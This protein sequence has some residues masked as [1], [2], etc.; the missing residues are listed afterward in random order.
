MLINILYD[1]KNYSIFIYVL[2]CH[3]DPMLD[4]WEFNIT[5]PAQSIFQELV[6]S[7]AKSIAVWGVIGLVGLAFAAAG[8]AK[9]LGV[10]QLHAS[11]A[12]MGLPNWFGYFIGVCE[13]LGAF[14]LLIP[15]LTALAAT[16]LIGIM[17]GAIFFHVHFEV[18]AHALPAVILSLLLVVIIVARHQQAVWFSGKA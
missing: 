7:K 15:R 5:D 18:V 6:M 16:G 10:P 12:I 3:T 4:V 8:I 2:G 9:L 11:F 1:V 17:L 13:L 14:G